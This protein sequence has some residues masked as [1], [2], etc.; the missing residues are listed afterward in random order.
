MKY[1]NSKEKEKKRGKDCR[2]Q[3]LTPVIPA[4]W[5]AE[6]DR[7]LLSRSLR[8]AWTTWQNPV[9]TKNAESSQ[10]WWHSLIV[11]ATW[12]AGVG[13]SFEPRRLRL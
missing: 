10:A 4:L 7:W 1:K 11:P 3:W 13:G 6:V 2:T 12:E 5:E 9:S 8:V